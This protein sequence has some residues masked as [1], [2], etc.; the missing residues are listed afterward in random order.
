MKLET[1]DEALRSARSTW[2]RTKRAERE[3]ARDSGRPEVGVLDRAIVEA[4]RETILRTPAGE[5][6]EREIRVDKLCRAI[7]ALLLRRVHEASEAGAEPLG[8]TKEGVATAIEDRLFR[9]AKRVSRPVK[10]A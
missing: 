8:Y 6:L 10:A 2:A 4:L 5:R 9:H 3:R 7:G 1:L